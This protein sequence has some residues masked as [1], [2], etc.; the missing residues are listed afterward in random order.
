MGVLGA[1]GFALAS[2]GGARVWASHA[3][4]TFAGGFAFVASLG[5]ALRIK[6]SGAAVCWRF[7]ACATGCWLA[8]AL[9]RDGL[10]LSG[11]SAVLSAADVL[12]LLFALF[13][14]VG[15][16]WR[17]PGSFSFPLFLLDTL[18]VVLLATALVRIEVHASGALGRELILYLYPAVY[19][20][21]ALIALQLIVVQRFRTS[22]QW[23]LVTAGFW[24]CAVAAFVWPSQALAG[25][26]APG[27]W[28]DALWSAG[29]LLVALTALRRALTPD[30]HT[31]FIPPEREHGLRSLAPA[32]ATLGLFAMPLFVAE[33]FHQLVYAFTVAAL[34]SL[35]A[36]FYLVR[37]T[38]ARLLEQLERSR[39]ALQQSEQRFRSIV[40]NVP[41]VVY[42]CAYDGDWTM[43][44][45]SEEIE[46]I[47]GYPASDFIGNRT[48]SYA[49]IIHP[50][51]A[52]M[53][54][55]IVHECVSEQRPFILEY[56]VVTAQGEVRWVYERGRGVF[57]AGGE[58]RCLD[59]AIFDVTERKQAEEALHTSEERYRS[60]FENAND[61]IFTLDRQGRFTSL[62]RSVEQAT[63]YSRGELLS[64]NIAEII[65]PEYLPAARAQLRRKLRG[66][67]EATVYELELVAKDGRRVPLELATRLIGEHGR[68]LGV[69]GIGRDIGERK[70]LEEQLRHQAFHDSLTGLPNRALFADRVEH[71]LALVER[72]GRTVA[73]LFL[74]L[75][76]F[77]TVNDS[78]GHETGDRLLA[79][80]GERLR[81]CLRPADTCARLG[82]DE[83][84][85]LLE[86]VPDPSVAA[87]T[88]ERI[89]ARIAEPFEVEGT[90]LFVHASVGIALGRAG[91]AAAGDLLRNADI[92][93]YRAK[94]AGGQRFVLFEPDM[95]SAVRDR[96]GLIAELKQALERDEFVLQ[97]QPIVMLETEAI[98]GIEALVRWQHPQRGLLPPSEFILLAEETGLIMPLCRFVL[99]EACHRVR[100]WQQA[101]PSNPPL[102]LS[103]NLSGVR[104]S[105]PKLVEDVARALKQSGLPPQ[106]L[107]LEITE[108]ALVEGQEEAS[109]LHQLN[110]LGVRLAIDDFGTGY[111]SLMYLRQFPIEILKID[112]SF[113][114]AS[115]SDA[116]EAR[117]LETIVHLSQNLGLATVAEG[118]EQPEQQSRLQK[119]HCQLGQGF[120]F[121]RPLDP[122]EVEALLHDTSRR[123][124]TSTLRLAASGD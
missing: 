103:V 44:F 53:M 94:A 50:D 74:D 8:G 85:I 51:D 7:W 23:W 117:F 113:I 40:A 79:V 70:Q 43:E 13:C 36:R 124:A 27:H 96:H 107:V 98:V 16:A 10:A 69:Q 111:A 60:L 19:S 49:S 9:L 47:S 106:S 123:P 28:S 71:A 15:L 26:R 114:D 42:Q 99:D 35:A 61:L 80:A 65:A 58:I 82:G 105:D 57:E 3:A 4:W 52:P 54:A 11:S 20:L 32:G 29:L 122:D 64:L 1:H 59:G 48:R 90:K 84:A 12:W 112:R 45:V 33:H 31:S 95:L 97:Y 93:M 120:H 89:L 77:K 121:A 34:L 25:G 68:A 5:A 41:G 91:E 81:A 109:R 46:A 63:G 75:D 2:S 72:S 110:E 92:A 76:D 119:L 102:W 39:H 115:S 108:T 73:A 104:L 55:D 100:R 17:S 66:K 14:V 22:T 37:R 24:L 78:H 62:N 30:T 56:R 88:A 83:F 18:P 101:F 38:S 118:I 67:A 116:R 86:D 87:R 21:L 6:R